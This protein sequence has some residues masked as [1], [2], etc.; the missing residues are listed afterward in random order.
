MT[1]VEPR[2]FHEAVNGSSDLADQIFSEILL[3]LESMHSVKEIN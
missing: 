1:W 2:I 3:G